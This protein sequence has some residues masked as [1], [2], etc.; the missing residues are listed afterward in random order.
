MF[1]LAPALQ[2][3]AARHDRAASHRLARDRLRQS[4]LGRGMIVAQL[5]LS[6]VLLVAAGL[7][8]R[9]LGQG[10]RIDPGF[11]T[12]NV[13]TT[14]L[15]SESWGYDEARARAFFRTL[16]ER[17]QAMDTVAAVS[18][19]AGCRSW[20]EARST[21]SRSTAA[22]CALHYTPVD[23]RYFSTVRDPGDRGTPV[24]RFDRS[25]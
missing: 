22:S 14:T 2:R 19:A 20:A 9:A 17:V 3:R 4:R 12:T 13:V 5:A 16:R 6:L 21:T 8:V 11:E 24:R 25:C 18:Y 1:G 15:D 10:R 7:F 23:G